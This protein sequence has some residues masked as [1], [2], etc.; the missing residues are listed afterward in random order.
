MYSYLIA[1]EIGPSGTSA[2]LTMISRCPDSTAASTASSVA[3]GSNGTSKVTSITG[4]LPETLGMSALVRL[5]RRA[6]H[7]YSGRSFQLFV[8]RQHVV[9]GAAPELRDG[10]Q[11][12]RHHEHE[13]EERELD[14]DE[15]GRAGSGSAQSKIGGP[16]TR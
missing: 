5:R 15:D 8:L 4:R 1:S 14:P 7:G 9:G 13:E 11:R 10:E 2:A 6:E 16:S 3:S 12:P